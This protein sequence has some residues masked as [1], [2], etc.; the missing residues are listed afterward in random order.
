MKRVLIAYDAS[1]QAESALEEL[2]R[3]GLSSEVQALVM[4]V[5]DVWLPKNADLGAEQWPE[6]ELATIR[7]ARERAEQAVVSA[8]AMA[9]R[10]GDQL[11]QFHPK[12]S[13]DRFACGDS[14]AWAI[15]TKAAEWRANL[16]L[17]PD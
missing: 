6:I 4:S 11:A 7:H 13:V 14:P 5:A 12:W 9:T 16:V 17:T 8:N 15:L 2:S 3:T 10:A 1:A